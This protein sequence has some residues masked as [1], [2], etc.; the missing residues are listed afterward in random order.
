MDGNL[1]VPYDDPDQTRSLLAEL[2]P[3]PAYKDCGV[4][5]LG[6]V[7]AHW[8]VRRL[9]NAADMRV[10]SVDEHSREGEEPARLCNSVHV[11]M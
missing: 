7:P 4:E 8:E 5:R 9:R 11:Y 3:Y 6:E 10:S 2:N 1:T